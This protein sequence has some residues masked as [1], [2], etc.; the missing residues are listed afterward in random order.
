MST[1]TDYSTFLIVD[2]ECTCWEN[3][4][5]GPKET[6]EIGAV[7]Y[8]VGQ[9][10]VSE[11]QRF[12]RPKLHLVLSEFCKRLTTIE[13]AQVDAAPDFPQAFSEFLAWS[14]GY[15]SAVLCSW[16]QFDDR[17][18]RRDCEL[19]GIPYPFSEH[20]NIKMEFCRAVGCKPCGMSGALERAGLAL[21]GTHHRGIDDARNIARLLDYLLNRKNENEQ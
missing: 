21:A 10:V 19:H 2:L 6:I 12:V 8:V 17:Q 4:P 11:F 13:Q 3:E 14:R 1:L 20:V 15:P 18:L 16:G 9:G 5:E 7:V